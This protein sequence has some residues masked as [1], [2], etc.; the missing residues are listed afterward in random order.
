MEGGECAWQWQNGK[1]MV[2]PVAAI[3]VSLMVLMIWEKLWLKPQRIRSVLQKQGI[4][5]PTPSFPLGNL[6]EIKRI[7]SQFSTN[8]LSSSSQP[9]QWFH[10]LFPFL[11]HW[12]KQYGATF[13][14]STGH[15]Q[16]LYVGDPKLL[17]ELN[18]I[19]TWDLGRPTYISKPLKP[20]LGSGI[21]RV[22]GPHWSFQ[23]NLVA[24]QFYLSKIQNMVDF[25][26]DST[27][28]I[29]RKWERI[30]EKSGG[31]MA[32]IVIDNDMKE[33]TADIISKAC[34]GGSYALG[35]QIFAKLTTLQNALG[36]LS[37]LFGF[38]YLRIFPTKENKEVWR[39]EKEIE[40]LILKVVDHHKLQNQSRID[41]NNQKDLLQVILENT[42]NGADENDSSG[43]WGMWKKLK[44]KHETQ[45][46]IV[47]IC[48]NIYFAG[49]DTTALLL[50]W[51][52]VQLSLHPHWQDCLRAEIFET[53]PNMSS[54]DFHDVDKFRKMKQLSMVI[55]ES[56]RLYG[57]GITT[58][59]EA[60][61]EL[62][63]GDMVVP[64]GTNI[65]VF[66][67]AMHRDTEIWGEDANEF[68]PERFE[69][70]VSEA[71]KYP[72]AYLP[73]GLG[74]RICAGQNFALIE[75]KIALILLLSKFS[76]SVSPNYRHCPFYK[77]VLFP[78]YGAPLMVTKL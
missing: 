24:P 12:R 69:R 25:M 2:W 8:N 15:R 75:A 78:K 1:E 29:M 65:L 4:R 6:S 61:E 3:V 43:A 45:K 48:K 46:L 57:P 39:L 23:R 63:V 67:T 18:R 74:S 71:C 68:K 37:V 54:H 30:I 41:Q 28:E 60:L 26:E 35:N 49:S 31:K 9:E 22:N 64:K 7:Q 42:A 38:L 14:Y 21:F 59:R 66:I 56:L 58:S 76:F 33:L 73:F 19:K 16:H 5:G 55:Q 44:H 13:M 10:S 70:G 32:E 11:Q 34:F 62:K 40:Q 20:L 53:F 27:K 50:T 51:I 72:Q 17:K 47:D 36:K 52:L 77:L